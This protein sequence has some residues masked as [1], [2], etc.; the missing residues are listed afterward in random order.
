M[1]RLKSFSLFKNWVNAE[2]CLPRHIGKHI[3]FHSCEDI[4][5][6]FSELPTFFF[7][8]LGWSRL[9]VNTTVITADPTLTL[10]STVSDI[11]NQC[12]RHLQKKTPHPHCFKT[13]KRWLSTASIRLNK[14]VDLVKT[15]QLSVLTPA[16]N[17]RA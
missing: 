9:I 4:S 16:R 14:M 7:L 3:G 11:V 1:W 2:M 13:H 15:W 12:K 8:S 6:W 5:L 10:R 17:L